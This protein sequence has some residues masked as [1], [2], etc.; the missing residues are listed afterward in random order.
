MIYL[1]VYLAYKRIVPKNK[2]WYKYEILVIFMNFHI[3]RKGVN[4]KQEFSLSN[5]V[6]VLEIFNIVVNYNVSL[7]YGWYTQYNQFCNTRLTCILF[8]KF[9]EMQAELSRREKVANIMPYLDIDIF[10]TVK[11]KL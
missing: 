11:K 6:W 1:F 5:S 3:M 7:Y 2:I 8:C 10:M 4:S 9:V